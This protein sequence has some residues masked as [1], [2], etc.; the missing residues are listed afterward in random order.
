M[1]EGL[2]IYDDEVEASAIKL[3]YAMPYLNESQR[4]ERKEAI[5]VELDMMMKKLS[6]EWA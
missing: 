4:N 1:K 2:R 3:S 6:V 5:K